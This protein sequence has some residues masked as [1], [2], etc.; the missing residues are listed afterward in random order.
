MQ[1]H[2]PLAQLVT[3]LGVHRSKR[4]IQQEV[5]NPLSRSVLE[6]RLVPGRMVELG[7][8][9]GSLALETEAVQ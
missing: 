3:N 4:L 1:A 5:V 2:E 6:G 7:V 8:R 9:G